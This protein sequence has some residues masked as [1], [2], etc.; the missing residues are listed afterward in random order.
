MVR[1]GYRILAATLALALVAGL[2]PRARAQIEVIDEKLVRVTASGHAEKG[3]RKTR[4]RNARDMALRNAVEQVVNDLLRDAVE[5]EAFANVQGDFYQDVNRYIQDYSFK[6]KNDDNKRMNVVLSVVVNKDLI[7][8]TLVQLGV[9]QAAKEARRELDRFTI[10]PYLDEANSSPEALKYK[11][12][13]YTRVRVFFEDQGIPTVGQEEVAAAE[14]DEEYL[15][16][17]KGSVGEAGDE[18]PALMVARNTPADILVKITATIETGSYGGAVTKKVILTIGAYTV[19]TGEFIGSGDGFSEPLALSS[20]S[21]SVAAGIDQAMNNAMSRVMDRISSFWR[22]FVKEGRPIKL[23]FTD[24]DFGD[25]R[26][27]RDAL[28]TLVNDQKRLKAAGNVSEFMVWYDGSAEDLM[29]TLYDVFQEHDVPL[30][31]DP[32]LISNTIRFY[33][34]L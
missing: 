26:W 34:K 29:Y 13:F 11:E 12:L 30:A 20:E 24:F 33:K 18:D 2:A 14:S 19:M 6:K 8:Q 5:R 27:V 7:Q 21:A 4:E 1:Q 28:K 32:V 23:I 17:V 15:A 9:I 25:I 31:E 16:K 22:D 3:R 10:M